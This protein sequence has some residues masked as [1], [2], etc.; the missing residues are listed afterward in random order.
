MTEQTIDVDVSAERIS[1]LRSVMSRL[2]PSAARPW[3]LE[4]YSADGYLMR[5]INIRT[6][7]P[8][9]IRRRNKK[10][11]TDTRTD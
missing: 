6:G 9:S 10:N 4:I 8:L 1:E 3:I 7:K 5:K 2:D 11:D